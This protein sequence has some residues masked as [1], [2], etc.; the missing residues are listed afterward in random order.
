MAN[1]ITTTAEATLNAQLAL[2][3]T[4]CPA[5]SRLLFA[6]ES[7]QIKVARLVSEREALLR[8][9]RGRMEAGELIAGS[10]PITAGG[11]TTAV[12]S[13]TENEKRRVV[14]LEAEIAECRATQRSFYDQA[15]KY[16]PAF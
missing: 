5:I 13:H 9:L 16:L 4:S 14:Q 6:I 3:A 10:I 15:V 8:T 11:M 1:Q 7:V 12:S 2:H